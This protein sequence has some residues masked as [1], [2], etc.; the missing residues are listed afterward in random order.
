ML[1][2]RIN[3][4]RRMHN[5]G[6]ESQFLL[7]RTPCL[8]QVDKTYKIILMVELGDLREGLMPLDLDNTVKQVLELKGVKIVGIGTNLSCFGEKQ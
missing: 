7:S 1:T 4:I 3:N 2:P 5:A 8:S 6:I